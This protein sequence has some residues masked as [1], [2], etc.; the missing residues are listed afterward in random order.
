MRCLRGCS[1]PLDATNFVFEGPIKSTDLMQFVNLLTGAMSDQPVTISNI[2][3]V[4]GA[5]GSVPVP[6]KIYGAPGHIGNL[7]ELYPSRQDPL[8]FGIGAQGI[9]NWG[10]AA[11]IGPADGTGLAI[12]PRL[13][14]SG[15]LEVTGN[16]SGKLPFDQYMAPY[17]RTL[18]PGVLASGNGLVLGGGD[19][20]SAGLTNAQAQLVVRGANLPVSGVVNVA[21]FESWASSNWLQF[22]VR[23]WDADPNA[24]WVGK[25]LTLDFDADNLTPGTAGRIT[26]REGKVGIGA[27]Q[28]IEGTLHNMDAAIRALTQRLNEAKV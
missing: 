21:S 19:P 5:Q 2:L 20:W 22:N 3:S 13:V 16:I 18:R 1:V 11:S 26:M 24:G 25:I 28:D 7:I 9:F 8:G 6:L 27:I 17:F 14:V 4:G 23:F 10:E 15:D 12:G